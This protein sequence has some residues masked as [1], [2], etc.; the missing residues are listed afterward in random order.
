MNNSIKAAKK[1]KFNSQRF[2][3]SL[4]LSATVLL[5]IV[6][7]LSITGQILSSAYQPESYQTYQVVAGDT[8]WSIAKA[9]DQNYDDIRY[10]IFQVKKVNQLASDAIYPGQAL[11]LPVGK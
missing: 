4:L 9:H 2:A 11:K 10:F 8:L 7:V 3:K 5:L 6:A 1:Y